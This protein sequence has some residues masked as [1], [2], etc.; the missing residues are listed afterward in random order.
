[1]LINIDF[2]AKDC[3]KYFCQS[4]QQHGIV[5]LQQTPIDFELVTRLNLHWQH[6]FSDP[7]KYHYLYHPKDQLGFYPLEISETAKDHCV[8]DIKEFFHYRP[9]AKIPA[10]LQ[11]MTQAYFEQARTLSSQLMTM[12]IDN[13]TQHLHHPLS[14]L[15]LTTPHKQHLLRIVHYP[16]LNDSAEFG[17]YPCAPHHDINLLTITPLTASNALE[18]RI[19]HAWHA[20]PYA[21]NTMLVI[22]GEM[23]TEIS[24]GLY[25][26]L[27]HRVEQ[28]GNSRT[29]KANLEIP[30]FYHAAPNQV[31][32]PRATAS[33]MLNAR[34]IDLGVLTKQID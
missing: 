17:A 29:Q 30:F 15:S 7:A 3:A 8:K 22:V 12:L 31:L 13:A 19:N 23:L 25:P 33:E 14:A 26:S 21:A 34:L 1:M 20:I 28:T 6:Y 4:L 27:C 5:L 9:E 24:Q 11:S 10:S 2:R 16:P 18:Y 32:S